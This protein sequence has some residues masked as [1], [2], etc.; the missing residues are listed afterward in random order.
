MT[1]KLHKHTLQRIKQRYGIELTNRHINKM[2][3]MIQND[4]SI[5]VSRRSKSRTT[6]RVTINSRDI[7]VVYSNRSKKIITALHPLQFEEEIEEYNVSNGEKFTEWIRPVDNMFTFV[8]C[9]CSLAHD[10]EFS[11]DVDDHIMFRVG[12]NK[13]ITD[14]QRKKYNVNIRE[15][16]LMDEIIKIFK[17]RLKE[18]NDSIQSKEDNFKARIKIS[19]TQRLMKKIYELQTMQKD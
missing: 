9:D 14:E 12:V 10:I 16:D 15:Y 4:Q 7:F 18:L 5:F 3:K 19:E 8:C 6:H 13:E 17:G 11:H 1:K 2:I